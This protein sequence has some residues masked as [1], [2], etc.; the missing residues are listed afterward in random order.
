M[1][2]KVKDYI[3]DI[4]HK[5]EMTDTER[6]I[7][8]AYYMG[9]EASARAIIDEHRRQVDAMRDR[10]DKCRYHNMAS[11]VIGDAYI[12][13]DNYSMDVTNTFGGRYIDVDD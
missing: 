4:L 12:Y 13:D 3:D 6:L 10:A 5:A 7:W 8:T 11:D 2:I 9:A 1:S